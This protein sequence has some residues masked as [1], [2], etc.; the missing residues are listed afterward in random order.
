MIE[1]PILIQD[2]PCLLLLPDGVEEESVQ[3]LLDRG[4]QNGILAWDG[5]DYRSVL[6]FRAVERA[7]VPALFIRGDDAAAYDNTQ[8]V[9]EEAPLLGQ[10]RQHAQ[11]FREVLGFLGDRF[12]LE[13]M[14][15]R[16]LVGRNI[17]RAALRTAEAHTEKS[18]SPH[19]LTKQEVSEL[20]VA[21]EL[22]QQRGSMYEM[23]APPRG[24]V[25]TFPDRD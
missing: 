18:G 12:A 14:P 2:S 7:L 16:F 13:A 19:R 5:E 1:V 10:V 4:L 15:Y 22:V 23:L 11:T 9:L 6:A 20:R 24:K 3:R 25:L 8:Y 21:L 17:L